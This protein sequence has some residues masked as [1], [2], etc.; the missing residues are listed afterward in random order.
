MTNRSLDLKTVLHVHVFRNLF[1][2]TFEPLSKASP[3][4][5]IVL[6]YLYLQIIPFTEKILDNCMEYLYKKA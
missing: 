3:E 4:P 1:R 5:A 2:P 6:F